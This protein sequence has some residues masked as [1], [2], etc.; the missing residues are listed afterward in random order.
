[1]P[2]CSSVS[3]FTFHAASP[4]ECPLSQL[5]AAGSTGYVCVHVVGFLLERGMRVTRTARSQSKAKEI[6]IPREKYGDFLSKPI[7]VDLTV[8]GTFENTVQDVDVVIHVAS[9]SSL[10]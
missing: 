8:P 1:M 7:T 5:F 4:D 2:P 6:K 3:S 10:S 9:V